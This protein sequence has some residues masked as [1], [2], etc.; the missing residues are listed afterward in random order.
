MTLLARMM[1]LHNTTKRIG[2][3][4]AVAALLLGFVMATTPS[5]SAAEQQ[6]FEVQTVTPAAGGGDDDDPFATSDADIAV[7]VLL[8]GFFL[9]LTVGLIGWVWSRRATD[10]DGH[11]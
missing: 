5:A 6:G 10:E 7:A 4:L 1:T 9:A 3:T 11:K 2:L 8:P